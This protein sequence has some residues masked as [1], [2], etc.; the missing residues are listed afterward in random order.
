MPDD[1]ETIEKELRSHI[2]AALVEL[3]YARTEEKTTIVERL[4]DTCSQLHDLVVHGKIPD[5]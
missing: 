3:S 2:Y 5:R 4:Y 1:F